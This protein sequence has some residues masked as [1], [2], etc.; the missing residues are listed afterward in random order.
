MNNTYKF[1]TKEEVNAFVAMVR[2]T[3]TPMSLEPH[4]YQ[5]QGVMFFHYPRTQ[6][7]FEG[8]LM[9]YRNTPK[10]YGGYQVNFDQYNLDFLTYVYNNFICPQVD[11]ESYNHI[12]HKLTE[13][14]VKPLR[15]PHRR[16][17]HHT[18]N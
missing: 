13:I 2:N 6:Y 8:W 7:M 4:K 12:K 18:N 10:Q 14:N 9:Q 1:W 3:K 15:N 17:E 16:P 5:Q 11:A